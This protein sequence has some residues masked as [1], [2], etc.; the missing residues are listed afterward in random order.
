MPRTWSLLK[1]RVEIVLLT[2]HLSVHIVEGF[3]PEIAEIHF[4]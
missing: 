4:K 1:A 3:A 2:V